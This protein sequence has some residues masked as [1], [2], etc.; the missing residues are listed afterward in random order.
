MHTVAVL[1]DSG[2]DASLLD[3]TLA[4]QM[5]LGREVLEKPINA[6]ALDGRLLCRV[7]HRSTPVQMSMSGNHNETLSF[8]LIHAPHQPVI[9]EFPW[10]RRHNPHIDWASG[11]IREWS[12]HCHAVCLRSSSSIDSSQPITSEC[13]DISGVPK[14]YWDL[15]EA[16][17]KVRAT[18]LPPHRASDCSIDLLPGTSPP[19]G[20]LFSLSAPETKS[21]EKYI[22]DS[23]DAGLIRPSSSPA[24]AGFFFVGKKDKTMRPCINYRGL[25]NITVKN[26]Y[27]LPLVSSAFELLQGATIFT[28]LDLRNAYHLVRI[29]EGDEWKTG[30]NTPSG[31]YEYLV[32]PFGLTNAPAVFQ[33]LVNDVLRDLLNVCVF[34]YLDDILI[35]SKSK[36]EHV[37]HVRLVLQRLLENHL[38]V[39]AEKCMFH[40]TEVPFLGF[41]VTTGNI[42]MDP[43]KTKAVTDWPRPSTRKELQRFLGFANFYRRFIRNYS[44]VAAPLTALTSQNIPF[45]WSS[46]AEGAFGE[47]KSRFTSAQWRPVVIFF[48][49]A[50]DVPEV[51]YLVSPRIF[52]SRNDPLNYDFW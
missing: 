21:M 23:L 49:G 16:F 37:V 1:I 3:I 25:N 31:H 9:L 45:R 28:K 33:G 20:R 7:T 46:V 10:L 18:S 4:F 29:R 40:T 43:D 17:N 38:F 13:Q 32:M 48:G 44:L 35:F 52:F 24:G 30:F 42:K 5:G 51:T 50:L 8:H 14:D 11:T 2:A 34:V 19:R 27:P 47:L 22:N 36:Q 6:T 41:V 12:P 15:K 26:R 39:K